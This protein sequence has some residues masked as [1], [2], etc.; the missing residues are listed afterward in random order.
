MWRRLSWSND[1]LR[2][3]LCWPKTAY[4]YEVLYAI[5]D[6]N[7]EFDLCRVGRNSMKSRI[8]AKECLRE[9]WLNAESG[10]SYGKTGVR[11]LLR[12]IPG[13]P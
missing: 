9:W 13:N 2:V 6:N 7:N 3:R 11:A 10:R 5:A 8:V 1:D 12:A 4:M